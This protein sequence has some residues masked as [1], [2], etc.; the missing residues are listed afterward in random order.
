MS[1][2]PHA[3]LRRDWLNRVS[4]STGFS[5]QPL[6]IRI[7]SNK[8]IH[9]ICGE[10]PCLVMAEG[11][12][13]I[14]AMRATCPGLYERAKIKNINMPP[15]RCQM[16]HMRERHIHKCQWSIEVNFRWI[17]TED[18]SQG[19]IKF[20]LKFPSCFLEQYCSWLKI[21]KIC[22]KIYLL[23]D[24]QTS[25]ECSKA[26]NINYKYGKQLFFRFNV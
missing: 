26:S 25:T 17:F 8:F 2:D 21:S 9:F 23:R 7:L 24:T 6:V 5:D 4:N 1:G 11:S 15:S 3:Q 20:P 12:S 14:P 16:L 13:Y 10:F 19:K 18:I 22:S